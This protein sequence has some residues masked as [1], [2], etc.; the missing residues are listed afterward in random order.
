MIPEITLVR[1]TGPNP[2]MTKRIF[3]DQEGALKSDGSKCRMAE[4]VATRAFAASPRDLA[5]VIA[6]CGPDTALTLGALRPGIPS[7]ATI[8]TKQNLHLDPSAITR[9]RDSI[10]YQPGR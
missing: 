6:A 9:S 10:D 3:L 4:G 2:I 1:K 5:N 8:T 7:P